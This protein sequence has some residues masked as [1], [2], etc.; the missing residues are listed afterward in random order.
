[1]T[2]SLEPTDSTPSWLDDFG[3]DQES[4]CSSRRGDAGEGG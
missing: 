4:P 2:V 1:M 3:F